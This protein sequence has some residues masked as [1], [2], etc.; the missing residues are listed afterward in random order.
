[1][2]DDTELIDRLV[3]DIR[4]AGKVA[5]APVEKATGA[6]LQV[7]GETDYF[8]S[9]SAPPIKAGELSFAIDLREPKPGSGATAG[10][11]LVLDVTGGCARKAA[12][13]A[14]YGDW[15][16]T[17]VPRGR[18]PDEKAYWTRV[19]PWGELSFG[20]AESAPDCLRSVV[21]KAGGPR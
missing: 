21:F 4:Q 2:S 12:I 14:R 7:T 20:F 17:D 6:H 11:L 16:L 18:S 1:M 3:Q 10:A 8:R 19:E 13:E 5:R 15:Q 9:Y